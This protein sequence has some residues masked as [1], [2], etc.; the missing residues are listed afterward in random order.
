MDITMD[1]FVKNQT[2]HICVPLPPIAPLEATAHITETLQAVERLPA[3]L[4]L[5]DPIPCDGTE[6]YTAK[7]V[8]FKIESNDQGWSSGDNHE[9]ALHSVSGCINMLKNV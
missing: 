2:K 9:G 5:T 7:N 8:I 4:L 6:S 3:C 1:I